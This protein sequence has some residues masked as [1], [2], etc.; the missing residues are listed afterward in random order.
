MQLMAETILQGLQKLE[1][2]QHSRA[3]LDGIPK[4][5]APPGIHKRQF[6][7]GWGFYATQ[8]F[9]LMKILLWVGAILS[10][11]VA[12]VIAWLRLVGAIDLQNAFVPFS[13]LACLVTIILWIVLM[14]A[15]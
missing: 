9:C 3:I 4:L 5:Q 15:T 7:S 6:N 1:L 8:G 14:F 13:F 12:F 10:P 11:G 2:G